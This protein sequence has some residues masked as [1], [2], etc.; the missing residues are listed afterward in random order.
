MLTT[1]KSKAELSITLRNEGTEAFKADLFGAKITVERRLGKDGSSQYR[2]LNE[3]RTCLSS[4][5]EF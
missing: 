5:V 1:T 4:N 2:L 3:H